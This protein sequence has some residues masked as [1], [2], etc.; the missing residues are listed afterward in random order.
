[1]HLAR[2]LIANDP[3]LALSVTGFDTCCAE[4]EVTRQLFWRNRG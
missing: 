4:A 1:M 2:W 3:D